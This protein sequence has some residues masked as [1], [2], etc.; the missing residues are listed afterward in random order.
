MATV[1]AWFRA[2]SKQMQYKIFAL[3]LVLIVIFSLVLSEQGSASD[4]NSDSADSKVTETQV[5]SQKT[6]FVH[7][8]GEVSNPGIYE[9]EYGTRVADALAAAGG[10]TPDALESSVN[11]AR[12]LNDGEQVWVRSVHQLAAED[13]IISLNRASARQLETLPGVG[14]TL[15]GRI[16]EW[17]D[18]NGGFSAIEQ[19]LEVSGI[20]AKLFENLKDTVTL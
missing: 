20:G 7:V 3:G 11:L 19:L 8:I 13:P 14:P 15:A 6:L 5:V 12:M 17:R 9:L 2:Q 18:K 16:I 10:L 1:L 4:S